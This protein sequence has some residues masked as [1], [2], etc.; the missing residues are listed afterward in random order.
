VCALVGDGSYLMLANELLTSVQEGRKI[1]VILVDNH[2]YQCIH[3]LQRATG[4]KSFGNELRQKRGA[5][6][7]GDVVKVD[8]EK[9][10]A[11]LGAVTFSAR[12]R[13]ELDDAL[14]RARS[15]TTSAVVVV[16]LERPSQIAGS[17]WWDVPVPEVSARDDVRA[18]RRAYDDAKRKQRRF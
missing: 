13:R 17:S 5:R 10:A 8:F 6:P 4:G 14:A 16:T 9:N 1:T 15:A 7:D 18:A 11:S 3:N 2:G 12:T